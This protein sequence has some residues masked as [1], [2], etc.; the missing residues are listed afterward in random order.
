VRA[1]KFINLVTELEAVLRSMSTD[2]DRRKKNLEALIDDSDSLTREQ[3][4]RVHSW[5]KLRNSIV[6][7]PWKKD[8]P[9]AEPRESEVQS[10]EKLIEI[11]VNPPRLKDVLEIQPPTVLNWDSEIHEFFGQMLPPQEYSQAPFLQPDGN[12]GLITSNAVARWVASGYSA[13]DGALMEKATVWEVFEFSEPG[14]RIACARQ[15]VT[16]HQA[17]ELLTGDKDVPPA[18]LLLTD[19]GS[20]SGRLM[21]LAVRA[22][23]PELFTALA[24]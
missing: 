3:K 15:D 6:H 22:D 14:D 8:I 17:I 2:P 18:A 4:D 1:N 12:Y 20:I 16:V 11:L 23:L 7:E 10:L 24:V 5:R 19:T 9:I 21:G 13:N